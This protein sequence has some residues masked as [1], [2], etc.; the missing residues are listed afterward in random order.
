MLSK[1]MLFI[2]YYAI[3]LNI[4][5]DNSLRNTYDAYSI[6]SKLERKLLY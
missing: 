6:L 2:A 3:I 5:E 1:H 4:L